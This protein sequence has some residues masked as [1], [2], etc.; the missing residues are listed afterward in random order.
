MMHPRVRRLYK[1]FLVL[2]PHMPTMPMVRYR[3]IVKRQFLKHCDVEADSVAF[4]KALAWGRVGLRE[5]E[6][7]IAVHKFRHLKKHYDWEN[8]SNALCSGCDETR[9]SNTRRTMEVGMMKVRYP[10]P[11]TVDE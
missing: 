5:V 7:V 11:P 8:S 10:L 9:T 1:G 6:A 2:G 3:E 4:K